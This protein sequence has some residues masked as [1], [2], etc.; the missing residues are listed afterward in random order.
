MNQDGLENFFG[1]IRSNCQVKKQPMAFQFRSAFTNLIVNNLAAKHSIRSNC[2]DDKGFGLLQNVIDI[3]DMDF[4]ESEDEFE[5]EE[6]IV[7]LDI[8]NEEVI[9]NFLA[10]EALVYESANVCRDVLLTSKCNDCKDTLE[11]Y[12]PL[13]EHGILKKCEI[14]SDAENRIFTY[15]TLLFMYSFKLLFKKVQT[16]L[17][18]ICYEK[19]LSQQ[20]ITSL[21]SDE[22]VGLGCPEHSLDITRKIKKLTVKLN[23][24]M[25]R[26]EINNIL[27]KKMVQPLENQNDIY[28]KAFKAQKKVGKYGQKPL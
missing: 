24:D 22:L 2:Q 1:N 17:P 11:A 23:I 15:P 28:N 18:F 6:D 3:Y 12:C 16:L 21:D 10:D 9:S 19:F 20:L 7:Q 27:C 13:T 14:S 5:D 25:F 26:K 4:E 8:D